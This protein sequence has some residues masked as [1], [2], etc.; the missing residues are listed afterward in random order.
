VL[1]TD[2]GSHPQTALADVVFIKPV[3]LADIQKLA[4]R[5]VNTAAETQSHGK[6]IRAAIKGRLHW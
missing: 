6:E 4:R 2:D 5:L 1:I 3:F